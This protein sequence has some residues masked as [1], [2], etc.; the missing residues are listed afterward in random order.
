MNR[1]KTLHIKAES[2]IARINSKLNFELEL[3]KYKSEHYS[4]KQFEIY[5]ELWGS[6][7]EL[8]SSMNFLWSTPGKEELNIFSSKLEN[9]YAK[10]EYSALIIEQKDYDE[11]IEILDQF[12]YFQFGK[13]T[14]REIMDEAV[15][16]SGITIDHDEISKTVRQNNEIKNRL[17]NYLPKIM[18]SLRK[19]I[20]GNSN[21]Q[22]D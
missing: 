10:L 2:E 3:F 20:S 21:Q 15:P 8:K 11:L 1:K 4:K 9:A 12:S 14:L 5:N 22:Q 16:G 17:I 13:M 7:C 6:L 18:D 19:Q